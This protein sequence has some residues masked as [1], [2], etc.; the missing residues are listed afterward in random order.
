MSDEFEQGVKAVERD[1]LH[2]LALRDALFSHLPPSYD[3]ALAGFEDAVARLDAGA[4]VRGHVRAVCKT[5]SD[6]AASIDPPPAP[7]QLKAMS[8]VLAKLQKQKGS[9]YYAKVYL[10]KSGKLQWS[11]SHESFAGIGQ[12]DELRE[13]LEDRIKNPAAPL[14]LKESK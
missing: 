4:E 7:D 14:K 8:Q 13:L 6:W 3:A 11:K 5:A 9:E 2:I 1:N 10:S 12:L